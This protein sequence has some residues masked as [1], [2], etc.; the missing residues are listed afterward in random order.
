MSEKMILMQSRSQRTP[1]GQRRRMTYMGHACIDGIGIVTG[2]GRFRDALCQN[3]TNNETVDTDN[4]R[5]HNRNHILH[6]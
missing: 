5:H 6:D 4:S 2:C 3:D 1:T